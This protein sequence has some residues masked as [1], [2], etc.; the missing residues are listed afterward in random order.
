MISRDRYADIRLGWYAVALL[1]LGAYAAIVAPAERRLNDVASHS[2]NLYELTQ[3]NERYIRNLASL[4]SARQRVE[5]DIARV[6][7]GPKVAAPAVAV[8]ATLER[9][10]RDNHVAISGITSEQAP[11]AGRNATGESVRIV[12]EG[13]YR[14]VLA[15]VADLPRHDAL[16]ELRSLSLAKADGIASL[17]PPVDASVLAVIYRSPW[18][19]VKEDDGTTTRP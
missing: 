16:I 2:R 3:R 14:D 17:L 18:D 11:S 19:L 7:R 13:R 12:L 10:G 15:V 1:L 5:R 4:Q 9:E 6:G 8:I